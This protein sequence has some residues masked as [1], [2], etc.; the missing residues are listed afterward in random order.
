MNIIN[1]VEKILET[2]NLLNSNEK[3]L[4]AFSGGFD[5]MCLLDICKN[6]KLNITAI[7][8]NHNWRGAE[9]KREEDNCSNYC[10]ENNI[11]FY[12][13]TLSCEVP[14]NETSARE[15]R[16][17]FFEKC[18]HNFGAK[19]VLTAHNANDNAE[20]VLYRI[21]KG[22][23][24]AGLG[25]IAEK[26]DLYIRP[27]ISTTRDEI[28]EYCKLKGI[29]PNQDSSNNN[30][31][32]RRNFIRHN[33]LPELEKINNNAIKTINNL[34]QIAKLDNEIIE[35]YLKNLTE[36]YKTKNFSNYS[37]AVKSRLCYNLFLQNNL[38]YDR[39]KI[40]RAINFIEDN[41]TSKSGKTYSLSENLSL[42]VNTE[43]IE[44]VKSST[45]N[46][47]ELSISK[48]GIYKIEDKTFS[49]E[50]C[51]LEITQFPDDSGKIAYVDLS[52]I[53]EL[54]LRYRKDGDKIKP[55]GCSGSQ[56]LKKYL[57]EKKVP[58]HQKDKLP[59]L[60]EKNEI[61][62]IPTLGLSDKIKVVKKTTH[63]LK[64]ID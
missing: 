20:T 28:E 51:A 57:N 13:E 15:A 55:L 39:E 23:G 60:A 46:D 48:N 61:L 62:W 25:G 49:I 12:S 63:V 14:Q 9:S 31:K 3:I 42:F 33:I 45:K 44:I 59:V 41:K 54:T 38:E 27:L 36:P 24:I 16:Y 22:T 6:L 21:T 47:V 4:I 11:P 53:T 2:Y 35:E 43:H 1:Q 52:N 58:K 30:I 8:L 50:E 64:L 37:Y 32:Y 17:I 5:S 26:R 56:K 7:H 40:S 29:K 34:S 19:A 10:K 18:A